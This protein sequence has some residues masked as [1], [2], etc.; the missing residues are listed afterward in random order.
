MGKSEIVMLLAGVALSV[1]LAM[2]VVPMFGNLDKVAKRHALNLELISL[3]ENIKTIKSKNRNMTDKEVFEELK[4]LVNFKPG[5]L[6]NGGERLYYFESANFKGARYQIDFSIYNP[7]TRVQGINKDNFQIHID[8]YYP[9]LYKGSSDI[10]DTT[11]SKI[12]NLTSD[13]NA[14]G[15]GAWQLYP[16]VNS[17]S[18][19][20]IFSIP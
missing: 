10:K 2:I 11:F 6:R 3:V 9:K 4:L 13:S 18:M 8:T 20:C 14:G 15:G 5:E 1:M 19:N 16:S 17:N 7:S 12:C